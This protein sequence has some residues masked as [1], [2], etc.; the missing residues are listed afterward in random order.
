[1]PSCLFVFLPNT[2]KY[3]DCSGPINIVIASICQMGKRI[4][5]LAPGSPSH[6]SCS[7]HGESSDQL[8]H[9]QPPWKKLNFLWVC[10]GQAEPVHEGGTERTTAFGS[11]RS[12]SFLGFFVFFLVFWPTLQPD[13]S[14]SFRA[15]TQKHSEWTAHSE[16]TSLICYHLCSR[17]GLHS[18]ECVHWRVHPEICPLPPDLDM[19]SNKACWVVALDK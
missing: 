5:P 7:V 18:P 6:S 9:P 1:M 17:P 16:S 14:V 10:E 19:E 4:T 3:C 2:R 8:N 15:K 11:S 12:V 13:S